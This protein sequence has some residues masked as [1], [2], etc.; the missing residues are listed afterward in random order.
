MISRKDPAP[1]GPSEDQWTGHGPAQ[2]GQHTEPPALF[3]LQ[4]RALPIDNTTWRPVPYG[5][6]SIKESSSCDDMYGDSHTPTS[7]QLCVAAEI[8]R[9]VGDLLWQLLGLR[10]PGGYCVLRWQS[11]DEPLLGIDVL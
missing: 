9:S 3:H 6:Q 7:Q 1:S 4:P 8:A 11:G 5:R 10:Y 2:E